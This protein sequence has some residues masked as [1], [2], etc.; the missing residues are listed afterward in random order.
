VCGW[1]GGAAVL[2]IVMAAMMTVA[3]A[4]EAAPKK[5][6]FIVGINDYAHLP[7]LIKAVNDANALA[8]TLQ[9]LGFEPTTPV[10]D[11]QADRLAF[12]RA[13]SNFLNSVNEGDTVAVYFSG[14]G[15]QVR[16]GE[17]T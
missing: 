11:A 1:R 6:A 16:G 5:R 2:L 8:A 7:K 17:R 12:H 9:A 10:I 4:A 13:G 14:H 15:L 3:T